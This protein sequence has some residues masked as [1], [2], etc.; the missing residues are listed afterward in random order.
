MCQKFM[1]HVLISRT[2]AA[3]NKN[4]EYQDFQDL[5]EFGGLMEIQELL[6]NIVDLFMIAPLIVMIIFNIIYVIILNT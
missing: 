4:I 5:Q 6:E 3:I 1:T 2:D